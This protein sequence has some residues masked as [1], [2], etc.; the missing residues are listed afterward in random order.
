MWR[1]S[2]RQAVQLFSGLLACG[3][4]IG[5]MVRAAIGVAPWDVLAQGLSRVTGLE[6]GLT[7]FLVSAAIFVFWIPL[8]ERPGLGT[9]MNAIVIP[10]AA[11]G[12]L[13][14]VPVSVPLWA[15]V[16][17]F[18]AGMLLFAV[19][20]GLYIGA[21]LG[22]G[23]RDG[24]M[25]GLHSRLRWPIWAA[26]GSVELTVTGIGWLLGGNVGVGTLAFAFGIGP[27][28]HLALHLFAARRRTAPVPAV[29]A[30]PE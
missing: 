25:T 21:G 24:L 7:T 16:V 9:I 11:Q 2:G 6:F 28:V 15:G 27:L 8:R 22:P 13:W 20:S 4:G 5:L 29:V 10:L 19:G 3:I 17:L 14:I 18:V 26:R 30:V 23:P 12:A 1:M